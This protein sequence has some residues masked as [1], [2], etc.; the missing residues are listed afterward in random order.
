MFVK[1]YYFHWLHPFYNTTVNWQ[2]KKMLLA[3]QHYSMFRWCFVFG[4]NCVV[5][6]LSLRFLFIFIVDA[7]TNKPPDTRCCLKSGIIYFIVSVPLSK[8]LVSMRGCNQPDTVM[9][10]CHQGRC[11]DLLLW[12]HFYVVWLQVVSSDA[13]IHIWWSTAYP[14]TF[15]DPIWIRQTVTATRDIK[16]HIHWIVTSEQ[17]CLITIIQIKPVWKCLNTYRA[18]L[19]SF[20]WKHQKQNSILTNQPAES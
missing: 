18:K 14:K 1:C 19:T 7:F 16:A 15:W 11:S 13:S 10:L 5:S 6:E 4:N 9:P 2:C 17:C 12:I 3:W 20:K 8:G